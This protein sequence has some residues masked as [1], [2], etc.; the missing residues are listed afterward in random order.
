[1]SNVSKM[2]EKLTNK[3]NTFNTHSPWF[4]HSKMKMSKKN[5]SLITVKVE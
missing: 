2:L 1:M 4:I 3:K 5:N